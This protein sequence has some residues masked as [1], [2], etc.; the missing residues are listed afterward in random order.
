MGQTYAQVSRK[1]LGFQASQNGGPNVPLP[2]PQPGRLSPASALK[3]RR[4]RLRTVFFD[5][6]DTSL[7]GIAELADAKSQAMLRAKLGEVDAHVT[8][9]MSQFSAVKPQAVSA[10][11]CA[12]QAR[13]GSVD[14]RGAEEQH[15]GAGAIQRAA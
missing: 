6:I 15:A 10:A 14:D 1:G 8:A 5:G 13:A 12:R 7:A 4:S 3:S 2:Q 9:A 11:P